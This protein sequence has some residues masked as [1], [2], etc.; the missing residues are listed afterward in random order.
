MGGLVFFNTHAI[1]AILVFSRVTFG[2]RP[3]W[4]TTPLSPAPPNVPPDPLDDVEAE[5]YR[6]IGADYDEFGGFL[7]GTEQALWGERGGGVDAVTGLEWGEEESD[8]G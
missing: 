8:E 1:L 4:L 2:H 7:Y 5:R 6:R 3:A